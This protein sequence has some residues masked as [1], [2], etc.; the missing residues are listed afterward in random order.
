[1][2][3][4]SELS[5]KISQGRNEVL[6]KKARVLCKWIVHEGRKGGRQPNEGAPSGRG[7]FV[8]RQLAPRKVRSRR[9]REHNPSD[10][11]LCPLV[12]V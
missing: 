11:Q 8:H 10:W 5:H 7:A 3:G 4:D 1:M 6:I 12:T 9:A 2:R